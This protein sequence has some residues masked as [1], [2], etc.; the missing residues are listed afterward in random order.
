MASLHA[1]LPRPA[2]E[3][4][5]IPFTIF[6]IP[7]L[8]SR[9]L[10]GIPWIAEAASLRGGHRRSFPFG[11]KQY[12]FFLIILNAIFEHDSFELFF[13]TSMTFLLTHAQMPRHP[14]TALL[15]GITTRSFRILFGPSCMMTQCTLPAQLGTTS[16]LATWPPSQPQLSLIAS[17]R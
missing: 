9:P 16:T 3:F 17:R 1:C 11:A 6:P 15:L 2:H 7:L 13:T 14:S 5:V 8:W 12:A 10:N 4:S